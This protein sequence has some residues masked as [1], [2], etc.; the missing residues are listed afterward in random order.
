MSLIAS[1]RESLKGLLDRIE[2]KS[3]ALA[4][5]GK[6]AADAAVVAVESERARLNAALDALEEKAVEVGQDAVDQVVETAKDV[7]GDQ[8]SGNPAAAE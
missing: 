6:D 4:V 1:A 3:K 2:D 5:A 7:I 8:G